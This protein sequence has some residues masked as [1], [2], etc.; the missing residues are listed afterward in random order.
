MVGSKA[1][2]WWME[3][4]EGKRKREREEKG[5]RWGHHGPVALLAIT[6]ISLVLELP[7][8]KMAPC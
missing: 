6:T 7:S 1:G 3:R 8:L 5:S 2:C 4:G